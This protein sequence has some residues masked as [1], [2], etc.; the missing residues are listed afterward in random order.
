MHGGRDLARQERLAAFFRKHFD[1]SGFI[2]PCV[3]LRASYMA[4]SKHILAFSS[5]AINKNLR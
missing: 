2:P 5:I 1:V 4:T 3:Q